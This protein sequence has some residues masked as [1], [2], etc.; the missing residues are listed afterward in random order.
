MCTGNCTEGS[1]R[2]VMFKRCNLELGARYLHKLAFGGQLT[3]AV[4]SYNAGP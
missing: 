2:S 4:L 1:N 3:L